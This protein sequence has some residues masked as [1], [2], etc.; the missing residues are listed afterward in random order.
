MDALGHLGP[1]RTKMKEEKENHEYS[2]ENKVF[3]IET[4]TKMWIANTLHLL[5]HWFHELL[6]RER[7]LD[8]CVRQ[9]FVDHYK[10]FVQLV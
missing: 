9:T 4:I 10:V 8:I 6:S 7:A 1:T 3:D 5:L 2:R